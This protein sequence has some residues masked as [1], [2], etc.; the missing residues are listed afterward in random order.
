MSLRTIFL[1]IFTVLYGIVGHWLYTQKIAGICSGDGTTT[2]VVPTVEDP[3]DDDLS[4]NDISNTNSDD[5]APTFNWSGQAPIVSDNFRVYQD[6]ILDGLEDDKDLE[7]TGHYFSDEE[8][9]DGFENMGRARA[10]ELRKLFTDAIDEDRIIINSKLV[11]DIEGAEDNPFEA[12]E[13]NWVT[14]S[15]VDETTIRLF[16]ENNITINFPF[17]SSD[18]EENKEMGD[19]LPE[20]A[21]Y[22]VQTGKSAHING[23]TDS[24]GDDAYNDALGLQR[25][26]KIKNLLVKFGAD[27]DKISINT[28]GEDY[29]IASNRTREGE[30]KNRRVEITLK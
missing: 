25:A 11:G 20:L 24:T 17:N 23:H 4:S 1:L 5:G 30:H 3:P 22:L 15:R 29:P 19:Y 13:F 10:N 6:G 27:K 8:I 14:R 18:K 2:A 9:P 21:E 16:D 28:K 12:S 7:I 26:I